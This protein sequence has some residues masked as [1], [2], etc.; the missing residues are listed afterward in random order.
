MKI[1]WNWKFPIMYNIFKFLLPSIELLLM[2]QQTMNHQ[3]ELSRIRN[4]TGSLPK[5]ISSDSN[6]DILFNRTLTTQVLQDFAENCQANTMNE[7]N[8][9]HYF[10]CCYSQRS[11]H[12]WLCFFAMN[13]LVSVWNILKCWNIKWFTVTSNLD[14]KS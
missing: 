9:F 3:G 7:K 1:D 13:S 5:S 2:W 8:N 14:L 10:S 11:H 12:P 6:Y 4:V